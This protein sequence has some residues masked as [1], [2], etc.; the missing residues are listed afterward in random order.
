MS[1]DRPPKERDRTDSDN[2][3]AQ[4]DSAEKGRSHDLG[5]MGLFEHLE[6]LRSRLL[7]CIAAAF[8]GMLACYAFSERL[9]DWLMLPLYEALPDKGSM[10]YTA[11]HEAFF[12]YIKTAFV[13]GIFLTSPYIFHQ[14]WLFVKPGLYPHERKYIVPISF[15]SALLFVGGAVFGYTVIFPYAYK[16]FMGFTDLFISPMITM[17]EGFSFAVRL[18]IAF[19]VVFELPLVIL[20]LSGLGVVNAPMLRKKRKYML[21]IFF[22]LAAFLTPPDLITQTLMAGPLILLYEVSILIAMI[23]GRKPKKKDSGELAAEGKE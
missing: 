1:E 2:P 18:L 4:E 9:F 16:F 20:F 3:G 5:E 10:I 14:F 11:P 23:F 13:A 21:L 7:R 6:E 17:K 19:G 12:I 22:M 8:I 15:C